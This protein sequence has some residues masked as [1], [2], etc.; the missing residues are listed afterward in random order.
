LAV[1]AKRL[2]LN[3]WEDVRGVL[4]V[5]FYLD[6]IHQGPSRKIWGAVVEKVEERKR[7][8]GR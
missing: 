8:G 1:G 6:R 7:A 2:R 4:G 5:F 3:K